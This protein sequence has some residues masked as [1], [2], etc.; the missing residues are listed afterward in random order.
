ML[1]KWNFITFVGGLEVCAGILTSLAVRKLGAFGA[2][3][4]ASASNPI[5]AAD[6]ITMLNMAI[7][8]WSFPAWKMII[9]RVYCTNLLVFVLNSVANRI[10]FKR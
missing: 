3:G 9:L 6:R 2:A 8:T 10:K 7:Q 4:C 1:G 5:M